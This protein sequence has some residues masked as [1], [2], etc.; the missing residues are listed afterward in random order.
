MTA[1]S[2]FVIKTTDESRSDRT[3]GYSN[4]AQLTVALSAGASYWFESCIVH[5][6]S[7]YYAAQIL[8]RPKYSGTLYDPLTHL[9]Y[10]Y[11]GAYWTT[12]DFQVGYSG[13]NYFVTQAGMEAAQIPLY[14]STSSN[15]TLRGGLR[16]SGRITATTAGNLA[17]NWKY[18]NN[19]FDPNPASHPSTIF[20][21]SWMYVTPLDICPI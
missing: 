16:I 6:S 5:W 18:T 17:M 11:T 21:G 1:A 10:E 7:P 4:D 9:I 8:M 3:A 20:A 19:G 2:T 12:A 15:T 13:L 14:N